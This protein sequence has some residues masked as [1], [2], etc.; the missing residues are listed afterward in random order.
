MNTTLLQP[1]LISETNFWIDYANEVLKIS[2]PYPKVSFD[3]RGTCAGKA[4]TTQWM[5]KYNIPLALKH[6]DEF[7]ADTV[8]HEV[9]HLVA[10]KYFNQRCG[11][12][13]KWRYIMEKV[14]KVPASRCHSMDVSGCRAR[15][16][17]RFLYRCDCSEPIKVGPKHH[18]VI[19]QGVFA[20]RVACRRCKKTLSHSDFIETLI[21]T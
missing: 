20:G 9:A 13:P 7:S 18:K 10:N 6:V 12:G 15:I 21:L 19:S 4:Y 17:K 11:H 8:P 3:L 1:R 5:V 2:L 14:F 16:A